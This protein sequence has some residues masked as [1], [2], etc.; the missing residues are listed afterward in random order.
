MDKLTK[1]EQFK[2]ISEWIK[3]N[4]VLSIIIATL[5]IVLIVA[6]VILSTKVGKTTT[7]TSKVYSAKIESVSVNSDHDW[8]VEG[9]TDAPDGAE[10]LIYSDDDKDNDNEASNLSGTTYAKVHEGKFEAVVD[11]IHLAVPVEKD[12]TEGAKIYVKV[13]AYWIST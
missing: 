11:F 8:K 12:T 9:T 3:K 6:F 4:K 10:I 2:K 1:S 5:I 13:I 7:S